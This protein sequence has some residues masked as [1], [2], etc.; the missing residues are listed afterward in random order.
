MGFGTSRTDERAMAMLG[1]VDCASTH[2]ENSRGLSNGGVLFA[3]A[4]LLSVGLLKD[5]NSYFSIPQG[6]F[7]RIDQ[8]FLSL[9]ICILLRVKNMDRLRYAPVGEWGRLIGLDR[10]PEK[11]NHEVKDLVSKQ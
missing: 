10:I 7:Y 8:L 2:F 1:A 4:P 3:L 11:E 9:A 6:N 5:L